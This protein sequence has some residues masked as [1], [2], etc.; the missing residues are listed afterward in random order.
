LVLDSKLHGHFQMRPQL[1]I[2]VTI[3]KADNL[4]AF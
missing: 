1:G 4:P 2:N 3:K